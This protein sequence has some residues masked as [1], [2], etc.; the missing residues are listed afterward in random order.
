MACSALRFHV[1]IF[2]KADQPPKRYWA[3]TT[4]A[5]EEV[6]VGTGAGADSVGEGAASL[7][8]A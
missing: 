8:T 3:G 5:M 6:R 1:R 2:G 4:M 7:A